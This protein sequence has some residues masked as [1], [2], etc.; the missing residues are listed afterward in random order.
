[1]Q[2]GFFYTGKQPGRRSPAL[3]ALII[4]F[5]RKRKPPEKRRIFIFALCSIDI[6]YCK[7]RRKKRRVFRLAVNFDL[8]ACSKLTSLLLWLY[9]TVRIWRYCDEAEKLWL[10][11]KTSLVK[12]TAKRVTKGKN[13]F[14]TE[15]RGGIL[16]RNRSRLF[17]FHFEEEAAEKNRLLSRLFTKI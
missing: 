17:P 13:V 1:M 5:A 9:N 4:S 7:L 15:P 16:T 12:Y 10:Q 11:F 14:I 6:F 8:S 2:T 3:P